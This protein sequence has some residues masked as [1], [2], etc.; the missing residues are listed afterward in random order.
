MSRDR[1][2]AFE[3]G[4]AGIGA[5]VVGLIV[6]GVPLTQG[7]TETPTTSAR[8]NTALCAQMQRFAID[9]GVTCKTKTKTITIVE[10]E[11]AL[12]LPDM[13]ARVTS[14]QATPASTDHGRKE[15]RLRV[16]V[17]V[18]VLNG[19]ER[20]RAIN[21]DRRQMYLRA[22][23]R[24]FF[25]DPVAARTPPGFAATPASVS[26]NDTRSGILRFEINDGAVDRLIAAGG[27]AELGV[28]P[29]AAGTADEPS[30]GVVR[31]TVP[32]K[33]ASAAFDAADLKTEKAAAKKANSTKRSAESTSQPNA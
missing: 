23:G 25:V 2:R 20:A 15:H 9:G 22:G 28:A 32:T 21:A 27:R 16:A 30:L 4:A 18:D 10:G 11:R 3:I 26:P 13:T 1:G 5:A 33:A 24:Q 7:D 12:R 19:S 17:R 31:L 14:V 8:T 29:F 6:G